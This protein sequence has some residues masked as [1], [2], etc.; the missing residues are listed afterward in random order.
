M[1]LLAVLTGL[2]LAAPGTAR[3]RSRLPIY[4]DRSYTLPE[5]AADLVARMTLA[6]K[7]SQATSSRAPAIPRLGVAAYGWWNEALHGVSR[8]QLNP[9]APTSLVDNTTSYPVD[10]ASGSSWDPG[11]VYAE[12]A[13]ISDEAREVVPRNSLNLD[14]FA[15]TINLTRDPRW[16]RNEETFSEDPLLTAQL[17]TGYVEGLQG[18][19]QSG[20]LLPQ[21]GGY[22]KA[23]AT[24]KHFPADNSEID[25]LGGSSA[26]DERTLREYYTA[27]FRQIIAQSHPGAIMSAFRAINGTPAPASVRLNDQLARETFGF[28][29]YLT[30]DCDA[31]DGITTN[32]HWQPPG[33]S[34]PADSAEGRALANAAGEDLNCNVS[35]DD[36]AKFL[37]AAA[38]AG[39][40]TDAGTYNV[41][42]LDSSLLRLFTAR[43][44]LGEF[45]NVNQEPWVAGARAQL[46]TQTWVNSDANRAVTETR[47]RLGLAIKAAQESF[48]LLRNS[49]T[50]HSDGSTGPLLPIQVPR[51]G[52]FRVAVI[53]ALANPATPGSM[54]LGGYSSLQGPSAAANEVTPYAGLRG[55]ILR[56]NPGAVVD[57]YSGFKSAGNAA[58]LTTIDPAAVNAAAGYDDVIVYTGTD[59]S[60]AQEQFDR[61][62]L[63]LPG[64]QAQ[65][66]AAVAARNPRT[67]AVMQTVGQVDLDGLSGVPALLWSSFTGQRT[68]DGLASVLFGG[69][70]PSGHLPFTWY[71][72]AAQLPPITDYAIRPGGGQPGRTYMYFRGP[73]SYPF[74]YGLSYTSFR[75][76]NLR[77]DH[78]RLTA[79]GSFRVSVDVTNTG[80]TTGSDLVQLYITSPGTPADQS[81]PSRRLEGFRQV[82]LAPGQA[83]TVTLTVRVSDLGFF[84]PN[85]NRQ[86]V[87]DGTYWALIAN[88]AAPGDV[89]LQQPITVSGALTA[90]PSVLSASPTMPGDAPRG[91]QSR[92][93]FPVGVSVQ[94]NLTVAM[95]D[96]SLYGRVAGSG[97]R[98]LPRGATVSFRSD[99][100][101]IVAVQRDGTIRT[102]ANGVA[103]IV[104]TISY[105]GVN[106][107]TEFVVRALS[108]LSRL[109]TVTVTHVPPKHGRARS[110]SRPTRPR[111][112]VS[113]STLP[114]FRPDV[115]SYDLSVPAGAP[116]PHIVATSPD[117]E[118]GVRV[119]QA[120]GVPG[121]ARVVVTGPDGIQTTY[122]AYLTHPALS[123]EFTGTSVGPQWTW[124]RPDPATARVA[125]GYLVIASEPGALGSPSAPAR[126]LLLQPAGGDW[127]ITSKLSFSATPSQEQQQ[128]GILAYQDDGN[129]LEL[130]WGFSSGAD[131]FTETSQDTLSG[132]PVTQTLVSERTSPQMPHTLWLRMV[133]RGPRY[134][135]LYSLDGVN[136]VGL[137]GVGASLSAVR[138]GLFATG[139]LAPAGP[140]DVAFDWFRVQQP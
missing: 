138:V 40:S 75:D 15:P 66:I 14:F 67:I 70:N 47:A 79:D 58:S 39:I 84:D 72:S 13:A 68:G 109:A 23:V 9:S 61:P 4:R 16:G 110:G 116:V 124:I 11:L 74:G 8:L 32:H 136:Y 80:R 82:T 101:G 63:A 104:A 18:E 107:S 56:A 131:R 117:P 91:I 128:A 54:F 112:R 12:G 34:R 69:Y 126:N 28:G 85:R 49:P 135:T 137:Y 99:R 65:L 125:S 92:V 3:T 127:T 134:S 71:Q 133:K 120:G 46:G 106:A 89:Q 48:V 119:I 1:G 29:G 140:L 53:G 33:W 38:G 36:Y 77:I 5:R 30:S 103:T 73:V 59:R 60:S 90:V 94:P 121:V 87:D 42:D 88:S 130:A 57:F 45:D 111:L 20:R 44:E 102:L 41:N 22:L 52:P 51:S 113:S 139:G 24:L 93:M 27:P 64:A 7:A 98:A 105:H 122:S 129:Y 17:A 78:R 55:A 31:V 132:H 25:R 96:D 10:L 95:N 97:M 6:E 83:R 2:M 81:R 115:L 62:A 35:S 108:E 100:P 76:S 43:M 21:G 19:D 114:G 123:D 86:T 118:A 26:I 37:P 50:T